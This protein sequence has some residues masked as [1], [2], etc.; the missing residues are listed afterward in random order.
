MNVKIS[1]LHPSRENVEQAKQ[2]IENALKKASKKHIIQYIL[3]LDNDDK[4]LSQYLGLLN[5]IED[6][7][8]NENFLLI[9]HIRGIGDSLVTAT[10]RAASISKGDILVYVKD[11]S[12][13]VENWDNKIVTTIENEIKQREY[14][15][16]KNKDKKLLLDAD[17]I[18][19]NIDGLIVK[20]RQA[21]VCDSFFFDYK[22]V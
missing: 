2:T 11:S 1:L 12:I 10:N 9:S 22:S 14:S 5:D 13:F 6:S 7:Y 17:K 15:L 8:K 18:L 3:S 19:E 20:T 16:R 4:C 21:Y